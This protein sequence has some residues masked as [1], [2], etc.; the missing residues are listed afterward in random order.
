MPGLRLNL[1]QAQRLCDVERTL[2]QWVLD[3]LVEAKF[4]CVSSDGHYARFTDGESARPRAAKADLSPERH[5]IYGVMQ[6]GSE[7]RGRRSARQHDNPF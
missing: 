2:C 3:S 4:L 1:E 7:C 5:V 6:R